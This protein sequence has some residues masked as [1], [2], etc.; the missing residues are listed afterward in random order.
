[1]DKNKINDYQMTNQKV[2]SMQ[3]DKNKEGVTLSNNIISIGNKKFIFDDNHLVINNHQSDILILK[4][5]SPLVG[6][7]KLIQY[8]FSTNH[9]IF[10]FTYKSRDDRG[11]TFYLIIIGLK[12]QP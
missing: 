1:M 4:L 2:K 9:A 12:N 5:Y 8:H 3:M 6:N 7:T 11:V 10:F